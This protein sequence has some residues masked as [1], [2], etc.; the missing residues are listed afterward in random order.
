MSTVTPDQHEQTRL[1]A[2]LDFE[3]KAINVDDVVYMQY[4]MPMTGSESFV[5]EGER[6]IVQDLRMTKNM[7]FSVDVAWD[8]GG[9]SLR[10]N[11]RYVA[12]DPEATPDP[13]SVASEGSA[14]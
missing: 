4:D 5:Y 12:V 7:A 13:D 9:Q 10:L 11:T 14:S 6:G 2:A 1:I 3:G 8:N